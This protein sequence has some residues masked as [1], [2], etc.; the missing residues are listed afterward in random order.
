MD[1]WKEDLGISRDYI[2]E[3]EVTKVLLNGKLIGFY[4][5]KFNETMEC[6]EIDHFWLLPEFIGQGFGK[7]VF[8]HIME[9]LAKKN[10]TKVTLSSDPNAAGFYEKMH[11]KIIGQKESKVSGCYLPI[12]EFTV[13]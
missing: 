5:L 9:T 7:R 4:A 3:N 12:F 6:Y 1:L 11:G 8:R 2:N 13:K 10:Q